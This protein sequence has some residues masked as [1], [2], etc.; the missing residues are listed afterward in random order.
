MTIE[1]STI[2]KVRRYKCGYEVRDEEWFTRFEDKPK[3]DT[4]RIKAAYTPSGDYI[5]NAVEAKRLVNKRGI[6][7]QKRSPD[8][9]VCSIGYS[10]KDGKWY[11]WSHRAIYGFKVG[12]RVE[13][14][15][16]AYV[17]GNR[18]DFKEDCIR[19]WSDAGYEN[20]TGTFTKQKDP[21][22]P[23]IQHGVLVKWKYSS[24]EDAVPNKALHGTT[25]SVFCR[26]PDEWGHGEWT[27][28]TT[29]DAK[30]MAMDFADGVS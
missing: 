14:G 20:I 28:E 30:Q 10:V 15:S 5:G 26:Y 29:A 27:A 24:D 18:K 7:P 6:Q 8:H 19:F 12:S 1:V 17:A 22:G 25:N 3:D 21:D 23:E 11:G 13:K 9:S 4:M 16:C 2:H